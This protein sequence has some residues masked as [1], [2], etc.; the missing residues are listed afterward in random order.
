MCCPRIKHSM[1]EI[2]NVPK[3]RL[4]LYQERILLERTGSS[5]RGDI[6]SPPE[7]GII[8]YKFLTSDVKTVKPSGMT[9]PL[10]AFI[11]WYEDSTTSWQAF[12]MGVSPSFTNTASGCRKLCVRLPI[13]LPTTGVL[14]TL[15]RSLNSPGL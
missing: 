12:M 11:K 10:T 3:L 15:R 14:C 5:A 8:G 9:V 4:S 2:N 7:F 1:L 13:G 6:S